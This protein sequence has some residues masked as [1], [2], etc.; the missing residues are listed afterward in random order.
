MTKKKAGK[1]S[2]QEFMGFDSRNNELDNSKTLEEEDAYLEILI[3]FLRHHKLRRFTAREII[4]SYKKTKRFIAE[5][6]ELLNKDR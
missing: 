3:D 4:E 2:P 5:L 1:Y 6:D